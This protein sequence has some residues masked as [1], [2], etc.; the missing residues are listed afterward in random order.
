MLSKEIIEFAESATTEQFRNFIELASS[1][2]AIKD[3]L[4]EAISR[5]FSSEELYDIYDL[6]LEYEQEDEDS[7]DEDEDEDSDW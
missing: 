7:E 2:D 6:A 5:S 4:V 3:N 1:Q